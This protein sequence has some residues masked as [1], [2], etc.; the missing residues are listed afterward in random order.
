MPLRLCGIRNEGWAFGVLDLGFVTLLSCMCMHVPKV[1]ICHV[2]VS[3]LLDF[4]DLAS[5]QV[6]SDFQERVLV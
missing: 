6:D 3:V 5:L 4:T 2:G 1:H